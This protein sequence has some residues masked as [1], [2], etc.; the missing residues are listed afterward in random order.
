VATKKSTPFDGALLDRLLAGQDPKKVLESDGL[1]GELKKALAERMLG[2]E[3][4]V[5]TG[6]RIGTRQ[7]QPSQ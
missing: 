3:I 1:I 5:H 2:G 6:R 4:S 7:R